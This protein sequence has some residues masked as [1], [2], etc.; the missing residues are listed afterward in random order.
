[1]TR[2]Q[3]LSKLKEVFQDAYEESDLLAVLEDVRWDLQLAFDRISEGNITIW[4][5]KVTT[6]SSHKKGNAN[7]NYHSSRNER[8]RD[9]NALVDGIFYSTNV[10]RL[11]HD[12]GNE[13]R[14]SSNRA[15]PGNNSSRGGRGGG[16]GGRGRGGGRGGKKFSR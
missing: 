12:L 13:K 10:Q 7:L 16:R 14:E 1:M 3:Q 11:K 4:E 9:S 5:K 6:K 15:N 8:F 2:E